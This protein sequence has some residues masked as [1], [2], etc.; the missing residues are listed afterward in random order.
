MRTNRN[1]PADATDTGR[2]L[3]DGGMRT[4]RNESGVRVP[5]PIV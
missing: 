5:G 3:A 2:S 4:N 1:E